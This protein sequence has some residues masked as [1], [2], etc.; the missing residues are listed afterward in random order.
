MGHSRWS[1]PRQARERNHRRP[2]GRASRPLRLTQPPAHPPIRARVRRD[3]LGAGCSCICAARRWGFGWRGYRTQHQPTQPKPHPQT[4]PPRPRMFPTQRKA[5]AGARAPRRCRA[6]QYSSSRALAV[7]H[8]SGATTCTPIVSGRL[9]SLPSPARRWAP[10]S[11][12]LG[13]PVAGWPQRRAAARACGPN[14]P[15]PLE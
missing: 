13:R 7:C 5:L 12:W 1:R 15:F 2:A 10:K 9:A 6:C 14:A 4:T 8:G 11:K 3:L